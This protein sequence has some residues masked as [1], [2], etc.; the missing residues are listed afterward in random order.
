MTKQQEIERVL[1][2]YDALPEK[3]KAQFELMVNT[4]LNMLLVL[5]ETSDKN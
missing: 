4:V 3:K 5:F 1:A 2:M